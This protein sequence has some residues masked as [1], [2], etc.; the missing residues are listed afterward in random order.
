[1]ESKE[2]KSIVLSHGLEIRVD[3]NQYTLEE[4]KVYEKGNNKGKKY[5]TALGYYN[6]LLQALYGVYK[7]LEYKGLQDFDGDL[8]NAIRTCENLISE[9]KAVCAEALK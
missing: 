6:T 5:Y 8:D 7:V 2:R 9:F 1:M 3:N 4:K